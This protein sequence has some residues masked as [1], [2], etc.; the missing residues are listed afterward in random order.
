MDTSEDPIDERQE[1]RG[2]REE[3]CTA[4]HP[5][6]AFLLS[7]PAFALLVGALVVLWWLLL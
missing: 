2:E 6:R 1:R 5:A 7:L 3:R 4:P